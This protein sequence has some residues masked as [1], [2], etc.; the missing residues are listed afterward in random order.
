MNER[1][2]RAKQ[3]Q[4]DIHQISC[5]TLILR[6]D[7]SDVFTD[8][9]ATKFAASLPDAR[10]LRVPDAGHTIQGDNPAGL[11]AALTPFLKE[12]GL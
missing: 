5:K 6:G 12:L 9:N 11:L 7:R 4:R 3:I 8:A 10:W 2:E 1:L